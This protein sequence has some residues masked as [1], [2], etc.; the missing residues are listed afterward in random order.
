MKIAGIIFILGAFGSVGLRIAAS[1]R[2]RCRILQQL[3]A[4]LRTMRNEIAC[5]GTPLPQVFALMA[6]SAD[7]SIARVFSSI[8]KLMDKRRWITPHNA[9]EQALKEEPQ[10]QGDSEICELLMSLAVGLGKYDR[11]SQ[12][13][14]LDKAKGELELLLQAAKQECS[15]R[16]KTYEVLGICAGISVTI[17]LI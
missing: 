11:S 3:L 16:S 15:V 7:G 13:Q 5:C 17:L 8:A 4:A 9:M 6:V 1:L 12:L 14:I 10:L 2:K